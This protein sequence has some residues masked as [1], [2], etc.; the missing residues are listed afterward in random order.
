MLRPS[1]RE[2]RRHF[3]SGP[4][5]WGTRDLAKLTAILNLQCKYNNIFIKVLQGHPGK[6]QTTMKSN[7][8]GPRAFQ[9]LAFLGHLSL[10]CGANRQSAGNPQEGRREKAL[11]E[12][13]AKYTHS[14]STLLA[15]QERGARGGQADFNIS[16][17]CRGKDGCRCV[18]LPASGSNTISLHPSRR[19]HP[20]PCIPHQCEH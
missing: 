7:V 14:G 3:L 5:S 4:H 18:K 1:R 6:N 12:N 15:P 8:S 2:G 17:Q 16:H 11:G 9:Q 10:Q 19:C 20:Q 13:K